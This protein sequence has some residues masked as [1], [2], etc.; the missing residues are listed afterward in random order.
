MLRDAFRFEMFFAMHLAS[1]CHEF[2]GKVQNASKTPLPVLIAFLKKFQWSASIGE[3]CFF[4]STLHLKFLI[5]RLR[6][7]REFLSNYFF[8]AENTGVD[9]RA[10]LRAFTFKL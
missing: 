8:R 9:L 3:S 6:L 5:L 4:C 7:S 10:F 1:R 2:F